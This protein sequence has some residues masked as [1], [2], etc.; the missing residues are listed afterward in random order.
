MNNEKDVKRLNVLGIV[1]YAVGGYNVV[2]MSLYF[3]G[4]FSVILLLPDHLD[5]LVAS[6][7]P[8]PKKDIATMVLWMVTG[9]VVVYA[10]LLGVCVII[11]GRNLRQR[12]GRMFSIIIAGLECA[13]LSVG[14]FRIG[15]LMFC[16]TI[17]VRVVAQSLVPMAVAILGI[18][19]L[20]VL[21]KDSVM[22]LYKESAESAES[23]K[24]AD[25]LE[26]PC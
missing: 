2:T 22:A 5:T 7:V 8:L 17:T 13:M 3:I 25:D 16:T 6:S 4:M 23:A 19:T 24:S 20:I 10:L 1:H 11:S 15:T 12:K 26:N 9:I 14:L 18:F 21:N